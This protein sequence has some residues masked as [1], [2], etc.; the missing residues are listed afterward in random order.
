MKEDDEE[1]IAP[2]RVGPERGS[3]DEDERMRD[4]ER[5]RIQVLPDIERSREKRSE[6]EETHMNEGMRRRRR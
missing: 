6:D 2:R 1:T 5:D 3:I 4:E